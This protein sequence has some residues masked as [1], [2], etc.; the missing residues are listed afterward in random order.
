[1][2]EQHITLQEYSF[3][4]TLSEFPNGKGRPFCRGRFSSLFVYGS[5]AAGVAVLLSA[6]AFILSAKGM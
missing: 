2:P 1:M 4:G 3:H 6:L 5:S